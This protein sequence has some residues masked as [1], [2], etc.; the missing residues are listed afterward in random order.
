MAG[1]PQ[2]NRRSLLSAGWMAAFAAASPGLSGAAVPAAAPRLVVASQFGAL[3]NGS[4][5]DTHALQATLDAA[6]GDAPA[7]ALIPAGVYR[8]TDTLRA[9]L[10]TSASGQCGISARGVH[11]ISQ[12]HDGRNILELAGGAEARF[13]LVEGLDILGT[14]R[15]GHGIFIKCD[16][17]GAALTNFCLRDIVVQNCGGDGTRLSGNVSEGQIVNS[18]F[19][20]NRGNG[21]TFSNGNEGNQA[22]ISSL[23]VF[24]C[25]FGDNQGHGAAL[26]DGCADVAFHGCYLL[27]NGAFGLAAESGCTLLSNC[28]FENNHQKADAFEHGDAGIQL[29]GFGTLVGCMAYSMMK[30]THLIRASVTGELVLVGCSGWGDAQ[31]KDAGL[32]RL[33]GPGTASA[34]LIGCSG[35]IECEAGFEPLEIAGAGG[36]V[37]FGSDWQSRNLPRFGEYRVWVDR[38]GRLRLKKGKPTADE[39]GTLVGT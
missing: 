11:F 27:L 37:K 32:A 35:A 25:I 18:Y 20:S 31:A 30:Q 38:R 21:A 10:T 34:T 16:G 19:R 5:D 1:A 3:G 17:R 24:G 26:V 33:A 12:M 9:R 14:G 7:I 15:D 2:L 23:H 36:G 29:N 13:V 28:G 8:I 22:S 6:F 4:A 39:D